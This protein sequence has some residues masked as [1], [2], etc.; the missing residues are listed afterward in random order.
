VYP[1]IRHAWL[2][3]TGHCPF[4]KRHP[5]C[6]AVESTEISPSKGGLKQPAL[7]GI[8]EIFHV[9][10][11]LCNQAFEHLPLHNPADVHRGSANRIIFK[12]S[13]KPRIIYTL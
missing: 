6:T 2:T 3:Q 12:K 4:A 9:N 7:Q 13:S 11:K 10:I 8:H 5:A 1:V